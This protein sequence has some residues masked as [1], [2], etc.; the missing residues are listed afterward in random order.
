MEGQNCMFNT[1]SDVSSFL[2]FHTISSFDNSLL[3]FY[4]LCFWNSKPYNF[5]LSSRNFTLVFELTHYVCVWVCI[6]MS[7]DLLLNL[8]LFHHRGPT[9]NAG[10]QPWWQKLLPTEPSP[11][12]KVFILE[13]A[14]AA[15]KL[16]CSRTW[17]LTPKCCHY[18]MH[19][20]GADSVLYVLY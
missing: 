20:L 4:G 7:K 15:L 16:A 1:V 19:R 18:S 6:W 5:F 2:V 10:R 12:P 9:S 13:T 14:Q 17:L 8:A 3:L 11:W